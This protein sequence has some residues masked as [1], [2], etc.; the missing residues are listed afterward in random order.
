MVGGGTWYVWGKLVTNVKQVQV[1]EQ[2]YQH[3]IHAYQ[4]IF[5]NLN[6]FH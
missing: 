2:L 6:T 5:L 4:I 1:D 3:L